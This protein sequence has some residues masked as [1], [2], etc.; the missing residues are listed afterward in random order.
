LFFDQVNFRKARPMNNRYEIR[1]IIATGGEATI[2]LGWDRLMSRE[3][4][5]KRAR[6]AAGDDALLREAAILGR[7]QHPSI[8]AMLDAGKDERGAFLVMERVDGRTLEEKVGQSPLDVGEFELIV[9]QTLEGLIAAHAQNVLHLDLKPQ[10]IMVEEGADGGPRVKILD[11][12]VARTAPACGEADARVDG[13]VMGSL[14]FMAPERFDR[15]PG[16]ERADLYSLG[17]VCYHALAGR[18]PF[19]GGTAAQVMVAHLRHQLAP[20]AEVRAGL[21][22]FIPQWIGWLINRRPEDRPASATVAQFALR[23][24]RM[25]D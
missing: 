18:S 23:N 22:P 15:E 6:T 1:N 2:H 3:V 19:D 4:A 21:P 8:V 7:I 12:G 17:C 16:D 14:F 5:V 13:P 25:E 11:F 24:R 9:T 10:N 20:L